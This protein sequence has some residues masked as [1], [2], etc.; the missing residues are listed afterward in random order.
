MSDCD[1]AISIRKQQTTT[2]AIFLVWTIAAISLV[3]EILTYLLHG[4]LTSRIS[5]VSQSCA[6]EI[7]IAW[8][9][10]IRTAGFTA[11][12]IETYINT[13]FFVPAIH[14]NSVHNCPSSSF[15]SPRELVIRKFF[16]DIEAICSTTRFFIAVLT[17]AAETIIAI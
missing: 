17:I 1:S 3:K 15:R 10:S 13:G 16:T 2:T 9:C 5:G 11:I 7:P 14:P 6:G 4:S 12:R 8:I